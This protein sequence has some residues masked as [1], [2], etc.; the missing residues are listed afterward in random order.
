MTKLEEKVV[1]LG[2]N[3][4]RYKNVK[5][6]DAIR[7]YEFEKDGSVGLNIHI[8][9]NKIDN[10]YVYVHATKYHDQS[11]LDNLQLAYNKLLEDLEVLKDVD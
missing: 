4:Y 3:L 1:D 7:R 11:Q 8:I 9:D 10:Y 6:V 2:Y 5:Y